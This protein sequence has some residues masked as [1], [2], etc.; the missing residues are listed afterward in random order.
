MNRKVKLQQLVNERFDGNQAKFAKAIARAPAQVNHWLTGHRKL[1]DAGARHI[2]MTLELR[3]GYF[4]GKPT[5]G[6]EADHGMGAVYLN[7]LVVGD[8]PADGLADTATPYGVPQQGEG[9]TRIDIPTL[10][11]VEWVTLDELLRSPM[12]QKNANVDGQPRVFGLKIQD[13]TNEPKLFQGS[14]AEINMDREPKPGDFVLARCDK[15]EPP[16]I[17]QLVIDGGRT[18]LKPFNTRYPI[19][20]P[21]NLEIVGVV[22]RKIEIEEF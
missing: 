18:F 6:L 13:D 2:E 3:Q 8:A 19:I 12:F 5:K 15:D 17:K 21:A 10:N 11:I 9:Y 7:N 1:G 14:I 4:D 22:Q 16:T 20:T